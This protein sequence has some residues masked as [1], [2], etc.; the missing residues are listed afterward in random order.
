VN[1]TDPGAN[2]AV[3][4]GS[5][6]VEVL[7]GT[8]C[9]GCTE[10]EIVNKYIPPG[11]TL[12]WGFWK[13]HS[14]YGPA[15][16]NDTWAKLPDGADTLFFGTGKTYYEILQMPPSG[17][18]A[19]L[20]LAHQYIATELNGLKEGYLPSEVAGW[21]TAAAENLT[22]YESTMDIPKGS[23]DRADAIF[24]AGALA[25]FNEGFYPGWKHCDD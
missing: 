20:I 1:E 22:Y 9:T 14:E 18:N 5:V 2:W 24:L 3:T 17:G 7:P 4:N 13:T 11:C 23:Q 21:M 10:V 6:Y 16:Y 8:D 19:Y 12:T 25:N 15:P